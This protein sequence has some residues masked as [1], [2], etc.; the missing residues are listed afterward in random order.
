MLASSLSDSPCLTGQ[1]AFAVG[2][3]RRVGPHNLELG[4]LKSQLTVEGRALESA[5]WATTLDSHYEW[6]LFHVQRECYSLDSRCAI[7]YDDKL[8][9]LILAMDMYL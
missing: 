7:R 3:D 5:E 1:E 4:R 6:N 2:D 8:R 9:H